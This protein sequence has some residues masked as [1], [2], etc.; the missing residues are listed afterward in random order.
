MAHFKPKFN[1]EDKVIMFDCMEAG[2]PNNKNKVWE[3]DT[4]SFM[5]RSSSEVVFLKGYSGYF[6]CK[7][8]KL[9]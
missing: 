1:K 2:R 3:C 5:S 4:D 8:L 6:L 7:Y 9:A